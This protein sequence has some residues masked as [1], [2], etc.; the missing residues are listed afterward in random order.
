M[1]RHAYAHEPY[2]SWGYVDF[3][4]Q[5]G[6]GA[7]YCKRLA[8]LNAAALVD[9]RELVYGTCHRAAYNVH[10]LVLLLLF[11]CGAHFVA[12]VAIAVQV[13]LPSTDLALYQ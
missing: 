2:V 10:V 11:Q 8:C 5:R 3:R 9:A 1:H 6:V 7:D 13:C 12:L 4:T